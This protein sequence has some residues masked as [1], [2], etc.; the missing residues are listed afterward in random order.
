MDLLTGFLETQ[1]GFSSVRVN[2]G[3]EP[4]FNSDAQLIGLL[5]SCTSERWVEPDH[6]K[7]LDRADV[8]LLSVELNGLSNETE[9]NEPR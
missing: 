8:W 4:S 7:A 3:T 1:Q 2:I 9:F 5:M 6:L